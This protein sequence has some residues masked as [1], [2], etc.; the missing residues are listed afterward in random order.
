M[1]LNRKHSRALP[2]GR[3]AENEFTS[4]FRFAM[5]DKLDPI[6]DQWQAEA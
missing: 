2:K 6:T 1:R 3:N 4:L 5:I